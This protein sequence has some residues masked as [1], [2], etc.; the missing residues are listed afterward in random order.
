MPFAVLY[1]AHVAIVYELACLFPYLFHELYLSHI[2][3]DQ[4]DLDSFPVFRQFTTLLLLTNYFSPY[5]NTREYGI[6][7]KEV[8]STEHTA[9]IALLTVHVNRQF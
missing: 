9:I 7:F 5:Y 1:L 2:F 4:S 3:L 6:A 8:R